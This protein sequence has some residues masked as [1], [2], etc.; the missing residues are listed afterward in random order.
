[1]FIPAPPPLTYRIKLQSAFCFFHVSYFKEWC[2]SWH[3]INVGFMFFEASIDQGH[4][5]HSLDDIVTMHIFHHKLKISLHN[6]IFPR[7]IQLNTPRAQVLFWGFGGHCRLLTWL[8][9]LDL[10]MVTA[11]WFTHVPN[12]SSLSCFLG[13]GR[14]WMFLTRVWHLDLDL[15]LV[16]GLR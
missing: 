16:T 1:M 9:H 5:T 2:G 8:W 6:C 11:L 4:E 3:L 12:F 7:T 14:G 13:F 15:D 10:D